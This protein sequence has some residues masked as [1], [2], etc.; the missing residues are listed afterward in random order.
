MADHSVEQNAL[1]QLWTTLRHSL[2][3]ELS[4]ALAKDRAKR[5]DAALLRLVAGYEL[6]PTVRATYSS[7]YAALLTEAR[8]LAG[9]AAI[10]VSKPLDDSTSGRGDPVFVG[11]PG[12]AGEIESLLTSL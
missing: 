1:K 7:R 9:K 5:A 10:P 6:L 3:P 11:I 2:V 4:S 8:E 12:V